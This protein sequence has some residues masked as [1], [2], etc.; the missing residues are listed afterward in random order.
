MSNYPYR[1]L[2]GLVLSLAICACAPQ[3]DDGTANRAADSANAL[4]TKA[5]KPAVK[6]VA[7]GPPAAAAEQPVSQPSAA[8]RCGWLHNPTPGN[9]WLVDGDGEWI[10]GAQ[11]G[12]QAPGMDELPDMSAAE[13]VE[14]NGHYGYGCACMDIVADP[15]SKRV[16]QVS[17]ANPRPLA[18]CR[19]DREL[20]GPDAD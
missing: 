9:W 2:A 11:G 1:L 6:A 15:A 16:L 7:G 19:A 20:P 10:L 4:A 14:V 18:K 13:W 5:P 8:R 17:R 3:S 12:Y